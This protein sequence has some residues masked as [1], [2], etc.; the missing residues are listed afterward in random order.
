ML[1]DAI[2]K[3]REF[4][5][6][7]YEDRVIHCETCNAIVNDDEPYF[8]IKKGWFQFKVICENCKQLG[9]R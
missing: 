5:K 8:L 4:I 9:R 3:Q 6:S 7:R 1:A 2:A